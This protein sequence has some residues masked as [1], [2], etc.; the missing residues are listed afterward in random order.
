M[1]GQMDGKRKLTS[2]IHENMAAINWT[3]K[4]NWVWHQQ[5]HVS[6]LQCAVTFI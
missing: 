1:Y 5:R 6:L 2:S 3:S 4:A